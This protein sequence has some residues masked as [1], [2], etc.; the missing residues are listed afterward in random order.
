M[1][2]DLDSV[3][4]EWVGKVVRRTRGRYPVEHDPIRRHCHMVGDTNP[5]FLDPG[6]AE[7]GPYGA[8]IVPPSTLIAYFAG[9]GPWPPGPK[10]KGKMKGPRF[11]SGVP[12]PGDRGI[13]LKTAW[14]FLLP[15]RVGD[16]LSAEQAIAD[17]FVKPIR[18]DPEAICIVTRTEISNHRGERIAINTNTVL[19]HRSP[20]Q[21]AEEDDRSQ[22]G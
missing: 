4:R 7:A 11:A 3:K 20:K 13:N 10:E 6:F 17:V 19:V 8:V 16:W 22:V 14:E 5:L 9:N 12:T 2:Y 15:A 21:V 1:N 18:L